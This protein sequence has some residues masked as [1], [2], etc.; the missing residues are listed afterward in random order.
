M[1]RSRNFFLAGLLG[2][3]V[4]VLSGCAPAVPGAQSYAT[5]QGFVT[6][7]AS[8]APIAGAT[9][10]VDSVLTASTGADGSYRLMNVPPGPYDYAV[11]ASG[12]GQAT[13]SGTITVNV[14]ATLSVQL[15]KS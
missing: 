4:V 6:D 10:T 2:A 14:P 5:L 1:I 8:N 7:R 13:G 9:V 11:T 15:D 3:A 12:Y